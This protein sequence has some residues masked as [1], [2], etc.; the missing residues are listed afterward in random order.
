MGCTPASTCLFRTI[1]STCKSFRTTT[2]VD[3]VIAGPDDTKRDASTRASWASTGKPTR[4]AA[5][6]CTVDPPLP[7]PPF[8]AVGKP[9]RPPNSVPLPPVWLFPP[10]HTALVNWKPSK[11][12]QRKTNK[13]EKEKERPKHNNDHR[14]TLWFWVRV[15]ISEMHILYQN[16]HLVLAEQPCGTGGRATSTIGS[17][18]SE[19][20]NGRLS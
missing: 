13:R 15:K 11:D 1:L 20:E 14:F 19:S 3:S 12:Q 6:P 4:L 18:L 8:S 16:T 10:N 9:S 5:T 17:R 2:T 7:S